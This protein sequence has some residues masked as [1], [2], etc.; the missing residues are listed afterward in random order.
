VSEQLDHWFKGAPVIPLDNTNK[1]DL[2]IW[3][4]GAPVVKKPRK[5]ATVRPDGVSCTAA[6]G[7]VTVNG[8]AAHSATGVSCTAALGTTTQSGTAASDLTGLA[9]STSVGTVTIETEEEE[10]SSPP[11]GG[12][13][14]RVR[15]AA[16]WR[17]LHRPAEVWLRGVEAETRLGSVSVESDQ[18]FAIGGQF[19]SARA[20]QVRIAASA[21]LFPKIE[22]LHSSRGT[23]AVRA[24]RNPTDEELLVLAAVLLN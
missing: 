22:F 18:R 21:S 16:A 13:A 5:N 14:S 10:G 20:G 7:T 23:P 2:E 24:I 3:A 4:A 1:G 8:A 17:R 9:A 19:R 12:G 15:A 11:Q 6:L